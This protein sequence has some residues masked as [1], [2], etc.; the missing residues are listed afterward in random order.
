MPEAVP[1]IPAVQ[2]QRGFRKPGKK[3]VKLAV[4]QWHQ[5]LS[6]RDMGLY[7][8]HCKALSAKPI[9]V[10]MGFAGCDV[11]FE[12]MK[13]LAEYVKLNLGVTLTFS[14]VAAVRE[15][16]RSAALAPQAIPRHDPPL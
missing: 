9:T 6:G 13:Y 12:V 1:D 15:G 5:K 3:A 4:E 10:G 2:V 11:G 16:P 8:E 7:I 14:S